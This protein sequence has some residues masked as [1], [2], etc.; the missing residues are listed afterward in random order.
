MFLNL[1]WLSRLLK[2]CTE[3]ME[4]CEIHADKWTERAT[5]TIIH[6][7]CYVILK[8]AAP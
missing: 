7:V 1:V 5:L 2:K 4:L 6:F 3:G 8:Y